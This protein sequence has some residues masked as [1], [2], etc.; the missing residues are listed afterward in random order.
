MASKIDNLKWELYKKKKRFLTMWGIKN[1]FIFSYN[2]LLIKNLRNYYY[3]SVPGSVL[4]LCESLCQGYCYDRS[5]L[6]TLGFGDDDFNIIK[7]G[8]DGIKLNPEYIDKNTKYPSKDYDSHSVAERILDD[9]SRWIYD[10][11][12]GLVFAKWLYF[13][14]ENPDI[15]KIN[16]KQATLEFSEYQDV[17]NANIERD[18]YALHLILPLIE[19]ILNNTDGMYNELAKRE[20][21]LLKQRVN[22]EAICQE[23]HEDKRRSR[24][25]RQSINL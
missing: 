14:I 22:Y 18:K 12:L 17:K 21:E 15:R 13:L 5:V 20:I 9:G 25:L 6:I 2:E 3:G 1:G 19:S 11:S 24:I 16:D 8:I 7:M 10:T 23:I 4:L